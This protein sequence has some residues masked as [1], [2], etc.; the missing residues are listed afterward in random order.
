M[1]LRASMQSSPEKASLRNQVLSRCPAG[2]PLRNKACSRFQQRECRASAGARMVN[3]PRDS[4]WATVE[5]FPQKSFLES[6]LGAAC[7]RPSGLFV[8]ADVQHSMSQSQPDG[9]GTAQNTS[10]ALTGHR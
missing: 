7:S 5:V 6:S 8:N 4:S 9:L 10:F 1:Q 3:S 2:H